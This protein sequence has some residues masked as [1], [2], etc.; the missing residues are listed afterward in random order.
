MAKSI[1][2]MSDGILKLLE[3]IMARAQ[4]KLNRK[5]LREDPLVTYTVQAQSW[6]QR[7]W[8]KSVL[9][10]G[11]IALVIVVASALTSSKKAHESE[12]VMAL[13]D[14][15]NEAV[16]LANDTT[17][18]LN[19]KLEEFA[20]DFK[21]TNAAAQAL[22]NLAEMKLH[23]G[24]NE[25]ALEVYEKFLKQYSRTY[26]LT[27]AALEGKATALENLEH[28]E[29]A[30]GLYDRLLSEKDAKH[31]TPF[32][33]LASGRCWA[34]AGNVETARERY[35]QLTEEFKNSASARTADIELAKLDM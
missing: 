31:A 3:I 4:K 35:T 15:G 10:I 9:V 12:A 13:A 14:L 16:A 17:G 32:N 26:M 25:A 8:V 6:L 2:L 24:E 19:Q 34:K 27:A 18:A 28:W 1:R 23:D 29:E 21:G 22:L 33:L 11:A 7:N 20:D 5:E 30:A